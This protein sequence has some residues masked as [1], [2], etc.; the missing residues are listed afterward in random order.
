[1]SDFKEM[2]PEELDKNLFK[3]IGKDWMLI[4]VKDETKNSRANAMTASWGDMGILW[5]KKVCTVYV[6]PQRYTYSLCEKED[7]FSLCFFDE[8]YR[9]ALKY[10]GYKSGRD[11]DKIE[12]NSL[13]TSDIDGVPYINEADTVFICKKLYSDDIKKEK[14]ISKELLSNYGEDDFHRFYICEIEKVLKKY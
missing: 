6:R 11:G 5:N 1:M 8:K 4:T 7:R 10:C 2:L 13:T 12:H 9:E 3:M 14:F